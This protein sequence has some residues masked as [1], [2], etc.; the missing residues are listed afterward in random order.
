[1]IRMAFEAGVQDARNLGARLEPLGDFHCAR[2]VPVQAQAECAQ[3]PERE[4]AVVR[5]DREAEAMSQLSQAHGERAV[6]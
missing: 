6:G 3:S 4:I 1:M 5:R 2:L